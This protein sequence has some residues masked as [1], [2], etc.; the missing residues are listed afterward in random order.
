MNS[1]NKLGLKIVRINQGYTDLLEING[2]QS[3]C[4]NVWDIRKDLENIENLDGTS[5][6]LMLSCA[7]TG[8]ILTIASLIDGRATDCISAWI[9]IPSTITISGKELIDI[10]E[11]TKKEILANVRNNDTLTQL[12]S[13]EYPQDQA[14]KKIEKSQ[15]D[16]CAYRCYGKGSTYTLAELLKDLHQSYYK[17]YKAIFLLNNDE[18]L[19]CHVGH[20]LTDQKLQTLILLDQPTSVD[21]FVPYIGNSILDK[22]M[23]FVE[24]DKIKI[25]W[26][27]NG[28]TTINTETIIKPNVQYTTPTKNQYRKFVSY[29][30][31]QV[32]DESHTSISSDSY[33][34]RINKTVLQS[35][36]K[37]AINEAT[38]D[39]VQVEVYS[40]EYKDVK[41][42]LDLSKPQKIVLTRI[43][44]EYEYMFP[45]SNTG[46]YQ[47]IKITRHKKT[48]KCPFKGYV[49]EYQEG[50]KY[51]LKF[52]PFDKKF[53][54]IT[55]IVA[56]LLL[57]LGFGGGYALSSYSKNTESQP[58][59]NSTKQQSTNPTDDQEKTQEKDSIIREA[60][61]YLDNT[62][63]WNRS[64]MEKYEPLQG[65]WDAINSK[66]LD[67]I[68]TYATKLEA[69]KT[70]QD[71]V[72][73]IEQYKDKNYPKNSYNQEG[74][75]IINI[76]KFTKYI[77]KN[78]INNTN[79]NQ[80]SRS[81]G[82]KQQK[83]ANNTNIGSL[84]KEFF[85]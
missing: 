67:T 55:P 82:N 65:L 35:G 81:N 61:T 74:D 51:Y 21:G 85:N 64:E 80:G 58:P 41:T 77:Q 14:L 70:F 28:Y 26:K 43:T 79:N 84:T 69:S 37:I 29:N 4:K 7:E 50:K 12:F 17:N 15:S 32:V 62:Q 54:I 76:N 3:W 1:N 19:K 2:N 39:N 5:A 6:V 53:W 66:N 25:E 31:I 59:V 75:S 10:I 22:K 52:K 83:D 33:E 34:L 36:Q 42:N 13:K 71:F 46:K 56:I 23:Y 20:N 30:A 27:R 60:T 16:E 47:S 49:I 68:L 40:K 73:I 9:Y 63:D 8:H 45:I 18:K 24:G 48:D 44:Y 11:A 78:H 57:L 72:K 38:I